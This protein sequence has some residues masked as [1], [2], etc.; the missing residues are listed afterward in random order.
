MTALRVGV[1][2]AA[3]SALLSGLVVIGPSEISSTAG[4]APSARSAVTLQVQDA[5]SDRPSVS[6]ASIAFGQ[7]RTAIRS[8]GRTALGRFVAGIP[9]HA[10]AR[11]TVSASIPR[12]NVT[13]KQRRVAMARAT[14][15]A[16]L[17]RRLPDQGDRISSVRVIAPRHTK[18]TWANRV[19]VTATWGSTR[20]RPS[21][22]VDVQASA[23]VRSIKV[24]WAP[25]ANI[26]TAAPV[27]YRAYAIEGRER[28][29]DWK[30][31]DTDSSCTVVEELACDITTVVIGRGY[32]VAVVA[33]NDLGASEPSRWPYGPVVPY[34]SD[35]SPTG[36]VTTPAQSD[37]DPPRSAPGAPGIPAVTAGDTTATL[38]WTAPTSG[39]GSITDYRVERSLF[40]GPFS[41][42]PGCT[43]IGTSLTCTATGLVN[44]TSVRFRVAAVNTAGQGDW[45]GTSTAATPYGV[46]GT[47][48]Q[49]SAIAGV[50]SA[51][52]F[53][54][55]PSANGSDLT[56]YTVS[57]RR[58]TG[59][60]WDDV[61]SACSEVNDYPRDT[62]CSLTGLTAGDEY[63]FRVRATNARGAGP[64]SPES[65]GVTPTSSSSAPMI[66][67][68]TPGDTQLDVAYTVTV[69]AGETVWS[70]HSSDDGAT[71]SSWNDSGATSSGTVT[72]SGLTNGTTYEVQL[73][74]AISPATPTTLV[75][76][77]A[78]GRPGTTPG[79]PTAVTGTSRNGYAAITW[80]APSGDGGSPL[81]G[82]LV[83]ESLTGTGAWLPAAGTCA[84]SLTSSTTSRNCNATGLTNGTAYY[85]RV[86]A[87]NSFGAG[88]ASSASSAVT[89][90]G[91]PDTPAAP[92][93]EGSTGGDINLS[94]TAPATNGTAVT[95]YEI[96]RGLN[97]WGPF[98][99]IGSGLCSRLG[100]EFNTASTCT[101]T[102][103]DQG[104]YY[105]TVT[106]LSSAGASQTSPSSGG[107]SPLPNASAPDITGITAG[108][109]SLSVAFTYSGSA[110]NL[111][112]STN[113]GSSWTTRSPS[114]TS[115]PLSITGLT[116]GT[117]YPIALRMV[118]S[119][120]FS[121][122]SDIAPGTPRTTPSAPAAP[123]GAPGNSSVSL[124]WSAPTDDGGAQITGYTVQRSTDGVT[125][126]DQ[127][128]CTSLGV[129]FTCTATGLTSG[130]AYTF[131]VAAINAAGTG[132]YST[133]SASITPVAATCAGGGTCRVGDT[134]PGGGTVF[135][136]AGSPQ[137]WGQY[138]EVAPSTWS[139]GT[140]PRQAW[141][142]NTTTSV[143]GATGTA[144]GTGAANT[145]AIVVD[146]STANRAATS[147]VAYNGGGKTDWYLPSQDELRALSA[148]GQG[149]PYLNPGYWSSTQ[150]QAAKAIVV[151]MS[152]AAATDWA[153]STTRYVRPIRAFSPVP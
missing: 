39:G 88:S 15:I 111:Q 11:V 112:Y 14:A 55:P 153:K 64:D 51:E 103:S 59:G 146:N 108:N 25:P 145:A 137:S 127:A 100:T 86:T 29:A 118:T 69:S 132:A 72:I 13:A 44:G 142:G 7:G 131:K 76:G 26:D 90:A 58:G 43:G 68:V 138:L 122:V 147:A 94:W 141:S 105:Y 144:I 151:T 18:A 61:T 74:L 37:D 28:P 9:E 48:A 135:Y 140:D 91:P 65:A 4:A 79:A 87:V 30:P 110:S 36:T 3:V 41:E 130:T 81:V 80:A 66:T 73:G 62:S 46:P 32:T 98:Y 124:S 42:Q 52:V 8:T 50:T 148:S 20:E 71:W 19:Q 45:S 126:T 99:Q 33:S 120:G 56:G 6:R 109:G 125:Y 2:F 12:G 40:E 152:N 23:G 101:D 16:G 116:N 75:S 5:I 24:A 134:G 54:Y 136:V 133:A 119:T 97:S 17:V 96:R 67:E 49:P 21:V 10:Q 77:S 57:M 34:G 123:T 128:G 89:P 117:T 150:S 78:S 149:R 47:P 22:P 92:T 83:E 93:G 143:A 27:T 70:R 53:W 102:V 82:Y 1:T 60:T 121:D 114:S 35:S 104:P 106:A 139:G 84:P 63:F 107:I 113:G 129:D 31:S 115:S 38:L 95:G 85:F